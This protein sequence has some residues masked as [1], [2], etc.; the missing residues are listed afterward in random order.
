M[1]EHRCPHPASTERDDVRGSIGPPATLQFPLYASIRVREKR[2]AKRA[3]VPAT[4]WA[5]HPQQIEA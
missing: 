3:G 2:E 4:E 1:I 5:A